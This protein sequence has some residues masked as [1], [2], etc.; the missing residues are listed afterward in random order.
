[1]E[2]SK[3]HRYVYIVYAL[4]YVIFLF[5]LQ[6]QLMV[7]MLQFRHL[8]MQDPITIIIKDPIPL[9]SWRWLMPTTGLSWLT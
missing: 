1:M 4:L 2:L 6:A 9:S 3:L 5:F 7:N 8:S